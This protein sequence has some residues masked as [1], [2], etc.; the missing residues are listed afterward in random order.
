MSD[1][2]AFII[3]YCLAALLTTF[4]LRYLFA[5]CREIPLGIWAALQFVWLVVVLVG[6]FLDKQ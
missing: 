1:Y 5:W 2:F 4:L 3:S 6:L